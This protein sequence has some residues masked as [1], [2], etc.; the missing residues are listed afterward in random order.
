MVSLALL[1]YLLQ[2]SSRA[3]LRG[4]AREWAT[5]GFILCLGYLSNN[6]LEKMCGTLTKGTFS[7]RLLLSN[8][9]KGCLVP[10]MSLG[11]LILF[12]FLFLP[13]FAQPVNCISEEGRSVIM[14]IVDV[15]V[16]T[17]ILS[18]QNHNF[19]NV[20]SNL[21]TTWQRWCVTQ[22]LDVRN[23]TLATSAVVEWFDCVW[24]FGHKMWMN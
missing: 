18:F 22:A 17:A 8:Q 24:Y 9:D 16:L 3:G 19:F 7:S 13:V 14:V 15:N 21:K 10:R 20:S 4:R 6:R 5:L 11:L 23:C 12:L 2:R 1:F